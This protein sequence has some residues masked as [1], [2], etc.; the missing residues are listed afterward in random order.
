[1]KI[2]NQPF[3]Q[4]VSQLAKEPTNK[5]EAPFG[6][7]VSELAHAK[8][9][10]QLQAPDVS[11]K[12]VLNQGIIQASFE[13]SLATGNEPLTLVYKAALDGINAELK[14]EFG[15]DALQKAY[16]KGIDI[17]PEATADRIVKFGTAFFEQYRANHSEL[18]DD[19]A[20]GQFVQLIGGGI[21]KGFGEAK[22]I[23]K[24]LQVL[25]GDIASNIDKTYELVQAGLKAFAENYKKTPVSGQE[26]SPVSKAGQTDISL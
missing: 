14:A 18:S 8:K 6:K 26:S 5:A 23:L 4:T 12:D 3:G 10:E 20:M 21:D 24:G 7:K 16:D 13:V 25:D 11:P 2:N 15:D 1:M 19:E 22:D 17:S 9:S